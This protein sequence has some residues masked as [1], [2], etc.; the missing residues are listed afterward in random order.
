MLQ[1][2]IRSKINNYD[3]N[4]LTIFSLMMELGSVSNVAIKIGI[5]QSALSHA[6][7]KL[8]HQFDDPLFKKTA[9]GMQSR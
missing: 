9:Q 6:L 4:L 8:R 3:L 5:T 1:L 2:S 7:K